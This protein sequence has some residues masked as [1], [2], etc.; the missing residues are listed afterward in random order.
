[1]SLLPILLLATACARDIP[2]ISDTY[3]RDTFYIT[4][5][6]KDTEETKTQIDKHNLRR[7]TRCKGE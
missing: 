2:V 6:K 5:S 1:M 3:C 7:E 4:T